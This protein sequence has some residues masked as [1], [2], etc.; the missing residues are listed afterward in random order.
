[1]ANTASRISNPAVRRP[2]LPANTSRHEGGRFDPMSSHLPALG[3]PDQVYDITC[4]RSKGQPRPPRRGHL[5]SS[6]CSTGARTVR[7]TDC[8]AHALPGART[9]GRTHCRAHALPGARTAGRTHCRTHALPGART[10]GRTAGRPDCQA[11]GRSGAWPSATG[12]RRCRPPASLGHPVGPTAQQSHGPARSRPGQSHAG[13][14]EGPASLPR[15]SAGARCLGA[16][17]LRS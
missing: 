13:P 11:Y 14:G 12:Q 6:R 7:R 15:S 3:H 10:A 17:S 2:R 4:A 16:I 1:M 8:R 5:A 9:A